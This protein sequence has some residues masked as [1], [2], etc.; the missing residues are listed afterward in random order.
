[1]DEQQEEKQFYRNVKMISSALIRLS[2]QLT[3]SYKNRV[4]VN[5]GS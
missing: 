2:F 4:T 3:S 1:M 5:I